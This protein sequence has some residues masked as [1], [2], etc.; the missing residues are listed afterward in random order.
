[1]QF[2]PYSK[3]CFVYKSQPVKDV[4]ENDDSLFWESLSCVEKI[5]LLVFH[6]IFLPGTVAAA[7]PLGVIEIGISTVTLLVRLLQERIPH[8]N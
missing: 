5:Q 3:H 6:I 7:R 1:M 8:D 2:L 4:K